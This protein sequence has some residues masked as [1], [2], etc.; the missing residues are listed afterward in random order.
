MSEDLSKNLV[1]ALKMTIIFKRLVPVEYRD[2]FEKIE[3]ALMGECQDITF[4]S[5]HDNPDLRSPKQVILDAQTDFSNVM[6]YIIPPPD[7]QA[8]IDKYST[9]YQAY[10]QARLDAINKKSPLTHDEIRSVLKSLG[11]TLI[12]M[13]RSGK[14][15]YVAAIIGELSFEKAMYFLRKG[16]SVRG[17]DGYQPITKADLINNNRTIPGEFLFATDWEVLIDDRADCDFQ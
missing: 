5:L 1:S 3:K 17:G 16:H 13:P 14:A 8:E 4:D 2:K 11:Y 9:E 7:L 10:L 12:Y 6:S 15:S